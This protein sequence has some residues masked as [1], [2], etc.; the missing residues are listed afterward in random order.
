MSNLNPHHTT[1]NI[2][3]VDEWKN[4]VIETHTKLP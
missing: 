4:D 2:P 1:L 3:N